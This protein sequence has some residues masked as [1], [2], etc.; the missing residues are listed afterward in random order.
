MRAVLC[1]SSFSLLRSEN[2][3]RS[4][5]PHLLLSLVR[6]QAKADPILEVQPWREPL[7]LTYLSLCVKPLWNIKAATCDLRPRCPR[8]S[9]ALSVQSTEAIL[10]EHGHSIGLTWQRKRSRG[11]CDFARLSTEGT[12]FPHFP[13][14]SLRASPLSF[15][16][17]L[18]HL[19]LDG[20]FWCLSFLP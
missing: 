10:E 13:T 15:E 1:V 9:G 20:L 11:H 17:C 6:M 3:L 14:R 19:Q 5:L 16:F 12:S 8:E 4:C 18:V 2:A 7:A